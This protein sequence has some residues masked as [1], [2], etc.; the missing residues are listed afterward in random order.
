MSVSYQNAIESFSA[1]V[2][3]NWDV[4]PTSNITDILHTPFF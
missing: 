1:F 2:V 4:M 3:S